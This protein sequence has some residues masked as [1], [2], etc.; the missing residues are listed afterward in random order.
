MLTKKSEVISVGEA[1]VDAGQHSGGQWEDIGHSGNLVE[2][3]DGG[4]PH[5]FISFYA[6][7]S[8]HH[9]HVLIRGHIITGRPDIRV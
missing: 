6:E 4:L 8:A 9:S 2:T 5:R 3:F 7:P 1:E